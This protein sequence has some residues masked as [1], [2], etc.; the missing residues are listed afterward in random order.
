MKQYING[1]RERNVLLCVKYTAAF[2]MKYQEQEMFG[3]C[4]LKLT[5]N[6][7]KF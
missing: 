4:T 6:H 7:F 5:F 1:V 2:D 3:W